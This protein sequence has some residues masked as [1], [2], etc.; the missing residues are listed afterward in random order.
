MART[1]GAEDA[2]GLDELLAGTREGVGDLGRR[3]VRDLAMDDAVGFHLAELRGQD[4]FADAGEK[5][6]KL[7]EALRA[8]AQMP[9]GED[10]PFAADDI[11]G[12]LHRTAVVIFQRGL[13]AYQNVRTSGGRQMVIPSQRSE[14]KQAIRL[15][16]R[17]QP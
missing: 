3:G 15:G 16:S 14:E 9:D 8:E 17:D 7:R 10:F 11:D 1:P 4:F 12:A 6:A 5:I 2:H 13:R